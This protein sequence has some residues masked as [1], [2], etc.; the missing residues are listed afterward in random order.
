MAGERK[1]ATQS[2]EAAADERIEHRVAQLDATVFRSMARW[3]EASIEMGR[4]FNELKKILGHGKWQRHFEETFAPHGITL[5]TAERYMKRANKPD[6]TSKTVNVSIFKPA[7][8]QGAQEIREASQQAETE[9]GAASGHNK[10]KKEG[11]L[12]K[13]PLHMTEDEKNAMDALRKSSHWPRAEKRIIALLKR[14]WV[15]YG[16]VNKDVKRRS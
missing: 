2:A 16:I 3:R 4:A 5:R 15:K 6:A 1:D 13:L 11:H 7:T 12:Y 10:L 9:V 8:D 14:L